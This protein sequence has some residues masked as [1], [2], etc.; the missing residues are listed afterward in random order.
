MENITYKKL[1]SFNLMF[2]A[3]HIL[4]SIY[5]WNATKTILGKGDCCCRMPFVLR[6][7]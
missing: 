4:S 3:S 7:P 1:K 5:L 6:S 2:R